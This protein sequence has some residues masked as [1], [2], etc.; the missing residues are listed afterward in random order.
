[1]CFLLVVI[2][3]YVFQYTWA[4]PVALVPVPAKEQDR[5]YVL[6][7]AMMKN[8]SKALMIPAPLKE[9]GQ[10]HVLSE[11]MM[12]NLSTNSLCQNTGPCHVLGTEKCTEICCLQQFMTRINGDGPSHWCGIGPLGNKCWG[13]G[14]RCVGLQCRNC[15]WYRDG[16]PVSQHWWTRGM[17]AC[18]LEPCWGGGTRCVGGSSCG[19][20]C[21]GAEWKWN[22]FGHFC[23]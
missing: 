8:L 21:H 20:C 3:S 16:Q 15:C 17:T 12:K 4:A 13:I 7:E 6:S 14:N 23:K 22:K 5:S 18:G 19:R 11:V 10:S 2:L 1:M 9:Q